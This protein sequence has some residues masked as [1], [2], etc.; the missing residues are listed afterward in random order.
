MEFATIYIYISTASDWCADLDHNPFELGA[1]FFQ[2]HGARHLEPN[3]DH[4]SLHDFSVAF[5]SHVA[6]GVRRARRFSN[7]LMIELIVGDSLRTMETL[8]LPQS[9]RNPKWPTLFD[10]IHLSNVPDYT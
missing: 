6:E 3:F 1:N 8:R 10:R 9:V 5:F 4:S 7:G 2:F